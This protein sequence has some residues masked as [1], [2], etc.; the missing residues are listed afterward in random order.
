MS[1]G[2]GYKQGFNQ[3]MEMAAQRFELFVIVLVLAFGLKIILEPE[4]VKQKLDSYISLY[5]IKPDTTEFF[6]HGIKFNMSSMLISLADVVSFFVVLIMLFS[7]Y[8]KPI[9]S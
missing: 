3:G 7:L 1:Y 4:K 9:V 8:G 2:V 5:L 6:E